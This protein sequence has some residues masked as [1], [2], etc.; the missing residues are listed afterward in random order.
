MDK[1]I[2]LSQKS[3]TALSKI[4]SGNSRALHPVIKRSHGM[5][6]IL[7][8]LIAIPSVNGDYEQLH[9][10]LDYCDHFMSERGLRI[11][12][13]EWNGIES[14]VA[15]TKNTKTPKVMLM[16]H[17][18]VVPAIPDM[19]VMQEKDGTFVGRGTFDMKFAA[20]AFLQLIEDVQDVLHQ[21]DF[22]IMFVTDE[23]S[24][25]FDGA[26]KLVQEGYLPKVIVIP[27]GGDNWALETF[28]KGIWHLTL[29]VNG[30][31]AHGSRPWEGDS[32][33]QRLMDVIYE[34][35]RIVPFAGKKGSTVN[36]GVFN[37]G[38]VVNKVAFEASA[39]LDF[40]LG[41]LE[42][43]KRIRREVTR[44]CKKHHVCLSGEVYA[45]PQTN[46]INDP[47][48]HSF[49]KSIKNVVGINAGETMSY[50]GTDARHFNEKGVPC[51]IVRPPGGN[52]HGP[53]EWIDKKGFFQLKDVLRDYLDREAKND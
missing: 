10:I 2:K 35:Q 18:D 39:Q 44:I 42:D 40:R 21:Y 47:M 29:T 11:K 32:A 45:P 26:F 25:G 1:Y 20:A 15:T 6:G 36:I 33:T 43:D 17:L 12:R 51:V 13:H 31:E 41:S 50:A 22:G 38:D 24:G 48:L 27:D 46:D 4:M 34:I 16:A 8:D 7:Q 30:K 14:M 52:L 49:A 5:D 23:E 37:G 28:C 53:A 3:L 19:F 9:A